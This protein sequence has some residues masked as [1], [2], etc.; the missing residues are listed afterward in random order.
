MWFGTRTPEA[1]IVEVAC[2]LFSTAMS[3]MDAV[4]IQ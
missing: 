1:L 3:E 2:R 4:D